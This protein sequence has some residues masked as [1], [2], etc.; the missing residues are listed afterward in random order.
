MEN[1]YFSYTEPV[2]F[3]VGSGEG[4]VSRRKFLP[5]RF[6]DLWIDNFDF[7]KLGLPPQLDVQYFSTMPYLPKDTNCLK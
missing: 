1:P 5:D 2:I 3:N 7:T 4:K 6:V